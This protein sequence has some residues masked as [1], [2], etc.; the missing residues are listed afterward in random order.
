M[1]TDEEW[2]AFEEMKAMV[3]E[4]EK[5]ASDAVVLGNLEAE[6]LFW[7]ESYFSEYMQANRFHFNADVMRRDRFYYW[8]RLAATH[9]CSAACSFEHLKRG[10]RF[11][12]PN[13]RTYEATGLVYVCRQTLK[14][15]F[16]GA[17]YCDAQTLPQNADCTVC[18]L[19]GCVIRENIHMSLA[20]SRE[21]PDFRVA[22][23]FSYQKYFPSGND[24]SV[25]GGPEAESTMLQVRRH[26]NS[27]QDLQHCMEMLKSGVPGEKVVQAA[28]NRAQWRTA[29]LAVYEEQ[30]MT[31]IYVE[32]QKTSIAEAHR[33]FAENADRYVKR[34]VEEGKPFDIA[35]ILFLFNQHEKPAYRGVY[36]AEDVDRIKKD[37]RDKV[38]NAMI[39]VWERLSEFE[40][41][42]R[43]N[44]SFHSCARGILVI[45][46]GHS[47]DHANGL[48][49]QLK[50]D[51]G[52]GEPSRITEIA[53]AQ[54]VDL[55]KYEIREFY[56]VPRIEGLVLAPASIVNQEKSNAKKRQ[57]AKGGG[58]GGI[59][60][61]SRLIVSTNT[62]N[63]GGGWGARK[64]TGSNRNEG[65]MP[66]VK[67]V[68]GIVAEIIDAAKTT[69]DLERFCYM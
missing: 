25:M 50:V 56:F 45:M 2:R 55:Q 41:V 36:F 13:G 27:E 26:V 48:C 62:R 12:M 54:S 7:R 16:C 35:H 33:A 66:S 1:V 51:R 43:D 8:D 63:K 24:D 44:T 68:H 30:V 31:S 5:N 4:S 22:G 32:Y 64:S 20:R 65:R 58:G 61:S 23:S 52:T 40:G 10:F 42:K 59:S 3:A 38:V 18:S 29:A 15:H 34:C 21:D 17:D 69:D 9:G 6:T 47:V 39:R 19:T 28:K 11:R 57:K 53:G 67:N 60:S 37:L 49:V 46:A 14:P